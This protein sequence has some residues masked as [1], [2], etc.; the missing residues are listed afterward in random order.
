MGRKVEEAVE[1]IAEFINQEKE[2]GHEWFSKIGQ[3]F[4]RLNK[5]YVRL[6]V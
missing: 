6:A 5:K 4:L 1:V 3:A 2:G